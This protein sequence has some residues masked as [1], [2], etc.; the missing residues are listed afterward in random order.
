LAG[1][2]SSPFFLGAPNDAN[3]DGFSTY[4]PGDGSR[5]AFGGGFQFGAFYIAESDFRFGASYKSQQWMEPF[6]VNSQTET[7]GPAFFKYNFNLPSITTFGVSYAG[8][9]RWLFATD[10][11]YFDYSNADGFK[12]QG[13]NP[14]GSVAGL[15]WKSIFSVAHAVQYEVTPRLTLRTGYTFNQNPISQ[16]QAFFNVASTLI[17]QHWYSLGATYRWNNNVTSTIAYTHGFE[18]SVTGPFYHPVFGAL[19][20]TSV[21]DRVSADILTAGVTVNF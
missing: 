4:G 1:L 8:I 17:I 16:S 19:A 15:G 3:G 21:T 12:Q 13:F 20:G 9:Q 7:G 14:D 18:N 2:S 5:M 6:R 11:K 10:F